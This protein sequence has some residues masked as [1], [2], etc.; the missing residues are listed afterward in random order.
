MDGIDVTG[1]GM[2]LPDSLQLALENHL[3]QVEAGSS[4]ATTDLARA[5]RSA[6]AEGRIDEASEALRRAV[7]PALD[8]TAAQSLSRL[9]RTLAARNGPPPDPVR[10]AVLSSSTSDQLTDLIELFL[11]AAGVRA[12]I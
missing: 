9:H 8:Y 2:S 6:L 11:F 4:N 5:I 12:S 3:T 10:V 1:W 7:V